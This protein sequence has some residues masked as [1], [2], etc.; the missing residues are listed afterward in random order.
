VA[1]RELKLSDKHLRALGRINADF[2]ELEF[3]LIGSLGIVLGDENVG[4]IVAS[5]LP[6][7]GL[8]ELLEALVKDKFPP[9]GEQMEALS[10]LFKRIRAAEDERNRFIHSSWAVQ[11][12]GGHYWR[13]KYVRGSAIP[14][15]EEFTS[16]QMEAVAAST[17]ALVRELRSFMEHIEGLN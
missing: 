13:R 9:P 10:G 8:T 4:S 16:V 17:R 14:R 2:Q 12:S 5:Y 15:V 7:K 11:P 3:I 6:F 1:R